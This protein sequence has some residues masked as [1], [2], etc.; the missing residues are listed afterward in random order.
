M[1]LNKLMIMSK[2]KNIEA[3]QHMMAGTHRLQTK[4]IH[5]FVDAE[6]EHEK[7]KR[8]EIGEIWEEKDFNGHSIWWE[9]KD[10]YRVKYH[11]HPDV[12]KMIHELNTSF[13]NCPKETC[14][15]LSPTRL[16]FKFQRMMGMCEDCLIKMET[17]MK[18]EGTFNQYAIDKMKA[19]AEA[20]FRDADK[21]VE[22]LKMALKDV[23]FVGDETGEVER[24]SNEG[25]DTLIKNIDENYATF[26]EKIFEKLT[27]TKGSEE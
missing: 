19:N 12:S 26:K 13:P 3:L 5:G 17:K 1:S 6:A 10:G 2:L 15:C 25:S 21:E 23:S 27:T 7:N 24:W 4:T 16:D 20:F 9:Q 11:R 22:V 18:L 14:T 8:R